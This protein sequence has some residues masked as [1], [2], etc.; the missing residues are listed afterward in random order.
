MLGES[1]VPLLQQTDVL[2]VGGGDCQYLTYW[3]LRSGLAD[4][5]PSLL[6]RMVFAGVSAG[7]MIMT[8]YGTTY[9]GHALPVDTDKSLGLIDIAL[10][11][12]LDHEWF[13]ENSSASLAK[14]AATLPVPSATIHR[15]S[16]SLPI[17]S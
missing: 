13:P 4:L 10:H 1:W 5:L 3:M 2:L 15:R 6:D 16:V 9:G 7:S 8:R 14:L 17:R 11:P 12:H